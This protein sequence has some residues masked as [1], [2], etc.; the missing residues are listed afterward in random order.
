MRFIRKEL[1]FIN[2]HE[3]CRMATITTSD[4]KP[5]LAPVCYIFLNG[6]FYIA[7]D[8]DTKKHH[9]I[10]RNNSVSLVVDTYQPNKA[11]MIEG[12]A[13]IIE[14]G[15][16]F[17]M[18]YDKFYKKFAWVRATPWDEGEAPFIKVKPL[19]KVSWGL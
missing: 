14:K 17:K 6:H 10:L 13:K 19:K 2:A 11:V 3:I 16:E 5:H 12:E 4:N 18:L 9:N 8:Y 7:T 15:K 1:G